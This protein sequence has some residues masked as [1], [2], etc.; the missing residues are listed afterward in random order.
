LLLQWPLNA[1][2]SLPFENSF[3][4][5]GNKE[6]SGSDKSG[7]YGE[8]CHI[9][10]GKVLFNH[11]QLLCRCAVCCMFHAYFSVLVTTSLRWQMILY[12]YLFTARPSRIVKEIL[13]I[14]ENKHNLALSLTLTFPSQKRLCH[15]LR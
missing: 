12:V 13:S 15:L 8:S 3:F 14:K 9:V 6:K 2:E 10:L 11:K 7:E 1:C 5:N 4:G